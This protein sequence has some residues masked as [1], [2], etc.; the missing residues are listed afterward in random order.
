VARGEDEE[1]VRLILTRTHV[2]GTA[3]VAR[4]TPTCISI[5]PVTLHFAFDIYL[6]LETVGPMKTSEMS[7]LGRAPPTNTPSPLPSAAG[8]LKLVPATLLL[9]F[10]LHIL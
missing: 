10:K 1:V 5:D 2:Y 3:K 8:E 9:I 4:L 7:Y 6:V